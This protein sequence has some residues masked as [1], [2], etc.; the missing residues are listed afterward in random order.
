MAFIFLNV[1]NTF[2][3][4]CSGLKQLT[5]CGSSTVHI[6]SKMPRHI[7]ETYKIHQE[8]AKHFC[9]GNETK[10]TKQNKSV[11]VKLRTQH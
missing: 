2:T 4:S 10:I 9:C 5:G 8:K 1:F 7:N 3:G 11:Q 6:T